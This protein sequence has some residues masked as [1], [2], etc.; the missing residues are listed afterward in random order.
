MWPLLR[1]GDRVLIRALEP[2]EPRAGQIVLV[3]SAPPV[4]HR[5]VETGTDW[6]RTRGDALPE[7]EPP[8]PRARVVRVA[9][10]RLRRGRLTALRAEPPSPWVRAV[11][12]AR[13][14]RSMVSGLLSGRRSS[15]TP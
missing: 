3:A 1:G 7:P 10:L 4:L 13:N 6:V 5:V 11:G 14:A 12:L 8:W 2:G 15:G 9:E